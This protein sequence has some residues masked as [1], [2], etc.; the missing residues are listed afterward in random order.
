MEAELFPMLAGSVLSRAIAV[1]GKDQN[2]GG[3]IVRRQRD[4]FTR[5]HLSARH[6][7]AAVRLQLRRGQAIEIIQQDVVS[8]VVLVL[9]ITIDDL[10]RAEAGAGIVGLP[11]APIENATVIVGHDALI[12]FTDERLRAFSGKQA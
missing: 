9:G 10:A 1:F 2:I 11:V 5:V 8:V 7:I 12:G 4:L 3:R 6:G